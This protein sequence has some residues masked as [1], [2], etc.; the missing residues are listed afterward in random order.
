MSIK[1]KSRSIKFIKLHENKVFEIIPDIENTLEYNHL[2]ILVALLHKLT[3]LKDNQSK[4][5]LDLELI[6]KITGLTTFEINICLYRLEALMI[7]STYEI[8]I[9]T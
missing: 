6:K 3:E 9:Y 1:P 4:T 7:I 2:K 8:E 5:C